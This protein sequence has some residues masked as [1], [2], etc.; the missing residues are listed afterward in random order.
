MGGATMIV[1]SEFLKW[2]EVFGVPT[3]GGGGGDAVTKQEVQQ[4]LFN[5][6]SIGGVDDAFVVNLS[7]PVTSLTNGLLVSFNS[8]S[9]QNNTTSPTLQINS[10]PPVEI[11]TFAGAPNPG[12]ISQGG[13]YLFIYN[14]DNNTFT[15]LNPTATPADVY[16]VQQNGYN[17]ALDTGTANAYIANVLPLNNMILGGFG[18]FLNVIHSNTGASTL[19]VNGATHPI[20][21][22]NGNALIG[23]E[24][25][26]HQTA[27][28][29]YSDGFSAFI[30]LNPANVV[31]NG[32]SPTFESIDLIAQ[33]QSINMNSNLIIGVSDPTNAQDAATKNY[34]DM[35]VVGLTPQMAVQAASTTTLNATYNNGSSGVGATLTNAG[36]QAAFAIDGYTASLNDRILINNEST[37][38]YNGIYTVTTVGSGSSN[39]VLTRAANYDTGSDITNSGIVPVVN[40]TVNAGTGWLQTATVVTVGTDPIVFIQFGQTAG[41]ISPAS[42]GTGVANAPSSTITLGGAVLFSGSFTTQFNLTGDTNITLPTSGTLATISQIMMWNSVAGTS[43]AAAVL[44]GYVIN[45]ALQTTITLPSTMNV[46]DRVSVQGQGAGGWIIQANSGQTIH[47]GNVATSVAGSL[48]STNQYDSIDLICII[49]NTTWASIGGPQGNITLA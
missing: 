20:V 8:G 25:L 36:S 18:V 40:G 15:L 1:P 49:A 22:S 37:P 41:I 46:G 5:T 33:A 35:V 6:S 34:V 28:F 17:Y 23:G 39:W 31:T 26:I 30:L 4:S 12:D 38:A 19:T 13:T 2:L 24:I 48:T 27:E 44:N 29:V 11:D 43:Q 7:P 14:A 45:N 32:S 10:L 21:L 3:G 42:G 16:I 9:L 47:I